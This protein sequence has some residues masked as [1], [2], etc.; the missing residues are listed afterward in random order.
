MSRLESHYSPPAQTGNVEG[1]CLF[2][3][4]P[5]VDLAEHG[6]PLCDWHFEVWAE[7]K[8]KADVRPAHRV[9]EQEQ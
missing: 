7:A 8:A 5:A 1:A 4:G 6:Q 9:G 3:D 2:C